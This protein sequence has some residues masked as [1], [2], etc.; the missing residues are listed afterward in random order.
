MKRGDIL[1]IPAFQFPDGGSADK[2][3]IVMNDPKNTAGKI[4]MVITTSQ[5]K[6]DLRQRNAS[7]QCQPKRKEFFF[8]AGPFFA[9]DTWAL[10]NRTPVIRSTQEIQNALNAKRCSVV[11][12]LS[13]DVVNAVTN[14]ISGHCSDD[15]TREECDLLGIKY[16]S[17]G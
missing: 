9:K 5:Q 17:S 8:P 6:G 2:L 12:T 15:L 11:N 1:F 13:D 16:G 4:Y 14:C 10:L 7:C 3:L